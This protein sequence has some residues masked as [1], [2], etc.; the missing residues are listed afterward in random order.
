MELSDGRDWGT[1]GV[2]E[3]DGLLA[4][5]GVTNKLENHMKWISWIQVMGVCVL[6][7]S[8]DDQ[9][10]LHEMIVGVARVDVD[11]ARC[12]HI[13]MKDAQRKGSRNDTGRNPEHMQ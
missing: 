11:V 7:I 10:F 1:D 2:N 5:G 8:M 3:V 12:D 9:E 4:C 13:R 6:L